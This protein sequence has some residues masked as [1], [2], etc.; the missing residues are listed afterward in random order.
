MRI[1]SLLLSASAALVAGCSPFISCTLMGCENGLIV[2]FDRTPTGP[3]RIE[4]IVANQA[5]PQVI[6]CADAANCHLIFRDLL[7]E[8]VTLRVTAQGA[9]STQ[10]FQPRYEALYPN[11]RE[12]GP[13]CRQAT[14]TYSL[15]G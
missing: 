2:R 4:A 8:Q 5:Q 7:A 9:T 11:G 6:D 12:C 14:V 3:F 15:P 13:S 10:S 1:R